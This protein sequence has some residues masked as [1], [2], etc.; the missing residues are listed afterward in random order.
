MISGDVTG[1]QEVKSIQMIFSKR[2][3]L[4]KGQKKKL[5][6]MSHREK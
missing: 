1:K 2:E 3:K 5:F 6:D 4:V